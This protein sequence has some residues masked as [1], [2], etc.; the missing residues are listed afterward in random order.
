[1]AVYFS[2]RPILSLSIHFWCIAKGASY[3]EH[4]FVFCGTNNGGKEGYVQAAGQLGEILTKRGTKLIYGGGKAGLMGV[5]ADAALAAGGEVMGVVPHF[6]AKKELVH[7]GLSGLQIVPSWRELNAVMAN[8]AEAFIAVPG[9]CDTL[10]EFFEPLTWS[11]LGRRP[12]PWDYSMWPATITLCWASSLTST[13][14]NLLTRAA[15]R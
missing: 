10:A 2:G 9:G 5:L 11:A 3:M 7:P 13:P 6:M 14:N 1:M 4:V 15:G 8:L 12:K